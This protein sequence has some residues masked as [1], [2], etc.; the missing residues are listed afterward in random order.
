MGRTSAGQPSAVA[1]ERHPHA[2]G[3]DSTCEVGDGRPTEAPPRGWGG[4]HDPRRA[5]PNRRGT[6]TRVGRTIS[7]RLWSSVHRR[8]PHA[9]G[10]DGN[11]W[12]LSR[13]CAEAPPRGWGGP[14]HEPGRIVETGGTPTRVGR[15]IPTGRIPRRAWRHPHAGGEDEPRLSTRSAEARGTPTR[16]GRTMARALSEGRLT[17]APPRGW[18]G[19]VCSQTAISRLRRHPHAGGEDGSWFGRHALVNEAPPREWGG[20]DRPAQGA[21]TRVRHPHA[22]GEDRPLLRENDRRERGTPTRVGRTHHRHNRRGCR[23]RHPHAGGEDRRRDGN[24]VDTDEAPPRGWGGLGA[25][26]AI[27][28][29]TGGTPTRVGRTGRRSAGW[30]GS[31]RHPHAGGED[32]HT[33]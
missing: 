1:A 25:A 17:E 33:D 13:R 24:H 9:G 5:S 22:G 2:G 7:L 32:V 12:P 21:A 23:R 14:P 26:P 29:A 4:P 10:E 28:A 15:T 31:G 16:V 11:R 8:H 3:E 6:P 18:G 27:S 30:R 19:R 20:P